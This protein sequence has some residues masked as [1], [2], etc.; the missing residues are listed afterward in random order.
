MTILFINS[1][2]EEGEWRKLDKEM[3]NFELTFVKQNKNFFINEFSERLVQHRHNRDSEMKERPQEDMQTTLG[4]SQ[5]LRALNLSL[6]KQLLRNF[7]EAKAAIMHQVFSTL[8]H[9]FW[10]TGP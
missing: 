1:P 4:I 2:N 5:E 10:L 7:Y 9:K 3:A 6:E 8:T